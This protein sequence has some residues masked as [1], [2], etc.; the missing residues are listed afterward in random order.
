MSPETEHGNCE[1]A[2]FWK[3]WTFLENLLKIWILEIFR[4]IRE[5]MNFFYYVLKISHFYLVDI[6]AP[7]KE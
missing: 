3:F 6:M 2:F 5:N 7:I 4:K 1:R